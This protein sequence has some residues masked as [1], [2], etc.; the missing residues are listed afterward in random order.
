ML[1][2]RCGETVAA[3]M[4]SRILGATV[5]HGAELVAGALQ[6][7]LSRGKVDVLE[8]SLVLK[9]K[10]IL[11]PPYTFRRLRYV[12]VVLRGKAPSLRLYERVTSQPTHFYVASARSGGLLENR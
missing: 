1:T 9:Y 12:L 4:L 6:A 3:R 10:T 5:D 7:A 2:K 8:L 11:M